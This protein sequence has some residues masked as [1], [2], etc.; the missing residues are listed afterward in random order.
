MPQLFPL[1][2][3]ATG[4][5]I[6]Y[7]IPFSSHCT[8]LIDLVSVIFVH[9]LGSA[10]PATWTKDGTF[11]LKDLIL[12]EIPKARIFDYQYDIKVVIKKGNDPWSWVY[13]PAEELHRLVEKQ[14]ED[15]SNVRQTMPG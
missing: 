1:T 11:W 2:P 9:G 10:S 13:E 14:K 3:E 5:T 8:V 6:E 12:K 7:V 4:T 15:Q